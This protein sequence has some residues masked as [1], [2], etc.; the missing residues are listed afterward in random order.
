[1]LLADLLMAAAWPA[2]AAKVRPKP[3]H[4]AENK[5]DFIF[6][7]PLKLMVKSR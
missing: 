5:V 7:L 2:W 3:K 6:K 4:I 1:M